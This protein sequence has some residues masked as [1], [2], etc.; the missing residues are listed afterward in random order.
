MP[1]SCRNIYTALRAENARYAAI[2]PCIYFDDGNSR[3]PAMLGY[4]ISSLMGCMDDAG[5]CRLPRESEQH[6]AG[7]SRYMHRRASL[8]H[9]VFRLQEMEEAFC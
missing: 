5:A 3:I 1:Q 4:A 6:Y 2:A 8:S 9:K 7:S